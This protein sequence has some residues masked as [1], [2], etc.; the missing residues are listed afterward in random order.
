MHRL[1]G[2]S[3]LFTIVGVAVLA[4]AG[5][6]GY[7]YIFSRPGEAAIRYIPQDVTVVATLDA[8]PGPNQILAFQKIRDQLQKS[9]ADKEIEKGLSSLFNNLPVPTLLRPHVRNSL[10]AAM[11]EDAQRGQEYAFLCDIDDGSEV[12]SILSKNGTKATAGSLT[13]YSFNNGDINAA[14][15]KEYLV[16]SPSPEGLQKIYNVAEGKEPALTTLAEYKAARAT[17]P[18]D[19]NLMVFASPKA[20]AGNADPKDP[21]PA[22]DWLAYGMALRNDGVLNS[23]Q[24]PLSSDKSQPLKTLAAMKPLNADSLSAMPAGAYAVFGAGQPGQALQMVV[25]LAGTPDGTGQKEEIARMEKEMGVTM[26]DLVQRLSGNALIGAYMA[27]GGLKEGGINLL[28]SIDAAGG[29]PG[30]LA[31]RLRMMLEKNSTSKMKFQPS[32]MGNVPVWLLDASSEKAFQAQLQKSFFSTYEMPPEAMASMPPQY[33]QEQIERQKKAAQEAKTNAE[34]YLRDKTLA[35]AVVNGKVVLGSSRELMQKALEVQQGSGDSMANDEMGQKVEAALQDGSQ[36]LI[37]INIG[38]LLAEFEDDIRKNVSSPQQQKMVDAFL[39]DVGDNDSMI[40]TAKYDGNIM[41]AQLRAPLNIGM[42]AAPITAAVLFPVFVQ[43]K[44]AAQ[45]SSSL[46]NVKQ[47]ALGAIMYSTDYDDNFPK[48]K[49]WAEFQKLLM[50]Y[51]KNADVFKSTNPRGPEMEYNTKLAGMS[52]MDVEM[53]AV[54]PL[55]WEVHEWPN[56]TRAVA[57]ADGHAKLVTSA[58]WAELQAYIDPKKAPKN[59]PSF[60]AMPD[61]DVGVPGQAQTTGTTTAGR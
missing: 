26:K 4:T 6:I 2:K 16:I 15:I 32:M 31:E 56:G 34:K 53:P 8:N 59:P 9:G 21:V 40:I 52:F 54:T 11:W 44:G 43:A 36:A 20:F 12:A 22:P 18:E 46:S 49:N 47:V 55:V 13:Y 45:K 58:Q 17:L 51:V 5:F 27:K 39:D 48:A 10:A 7:K 57:F 23:L 30:P 35:I 41:H 38:K 25:D 1:R 24:L 29:D 42:T 28:L 19:S 61:V 50:P 14:V 60:M 3:I 37:S 33:R